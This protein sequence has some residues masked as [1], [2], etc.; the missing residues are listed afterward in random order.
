MELAVE[1][2]GPG[3]HR[4]GRPLDGVARGVVAVLVVHRVDGGGLAVPAEPGHV[5]V[6]GGAHDRVAGR[7]LGGV[8]LVPR[9]AELAPLVRAEHHFVDV[10]VQA[11]VHPCE[12][13]GPGNGGA[14]RTEL[15]TVLPA[16]VV[17]DGP[18]RSLLDQAR[19][20]PQGEID[21]GVRHPRAGD[22]GIAP[23]NGG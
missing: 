14:A 15:P 16:D 3:V 12:C 6:R 23:D 8:P 11:D 5:V 10:V 18:A 17:Q 21:V 4:G 1:R 2:A 13:G 9:G 7:G 20:I 22:S 19:R